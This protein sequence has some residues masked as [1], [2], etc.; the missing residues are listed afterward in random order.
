MV[1]ADPHPLDDPMHTFD[2]DLNP[3]K[4][5]LELFS[6]TDYFFQYVFE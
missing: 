1:G 4:L 5:R 3:D 6:D 2:A